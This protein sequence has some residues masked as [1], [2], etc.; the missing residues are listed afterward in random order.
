MPSAPVGRCSSPRRSPAASGA[1]TRRPAPSRSSPAGCPPASRVRSSSALG[2]STSRSSARPRT[3]WS[4]ASARTSAATTSSAST[5]WTARTAS[6]S[7]LTSARGPWPIR[8]H[9]TFFV[10]TGFQYAIET[11]RGGFLV[12]DGHHNRVLRVT[13]DGEIT[14]LIAFGN[15]VPTGLAVSG[16][17]IYMAEAGPIPHLPEDG[18]VVSFGPK[19]TDRHGGGLRRQAGR[20]RGVR[21][22][23]HALRP[24]AGLLGRPV[25][26]DS[27]AAE[28]R[29]ARGGQRGRHLHTVVGGLDRPTSVEII[30][31]TAYV[32]TLA[33]EIWKIDEYLGSALRRLR[34]SRWGPEARRFVARQQSGNL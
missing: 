32:V 27:G 8:R 13:L 23:A 16:N 17:T 9:P 29:R 22:R 5:E 10:P 30:K 11:Y 7:S 21:P 15:I 19:S 12:T 34:L 20:R 31:N 3:R 6:P 28:H 2:W 1:S 24:L 25:R 18:K 26:G 4:P 33:G 14:E